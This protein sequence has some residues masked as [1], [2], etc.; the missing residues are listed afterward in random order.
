[1]GLQLAYV[2]ITLTL[3]YPKGQVQGNAL[4]AMNFLKMMID[5]VMITIA[6]KPSIAEHVWAFDWHIYI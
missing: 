3:T 5:I 2:H 4:L 6:I 1:M